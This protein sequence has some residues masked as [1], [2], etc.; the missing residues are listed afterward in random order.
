MKIKWWMVLL[1]IL[2]PEFLLAQSIKNNGIKLGYTSSGIYGTF[3]ENTYNLTSR[4]N[5]YHAALFIEYCNY[6]FFSLVSQIEYA[7]K[8]FIEKQAETDETGQ[9]IQDVKANTRLDYVSIPLFV[10]IKYSKI[11]LN[12]YVIFGPRFDYLVNRRNGIFK[13]SKIDFNS[14]FADYLNINK[15]VF[16]S[17]IGMGFNLPKISLFESFLELRYNH[18]FT[19]SFFINEENTVRNNSFDLWLGISF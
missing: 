2:L 11:K 6:S 16:G 1:L 13:F 12:P 4:R 18:D 3:S 14:Q 19:D 9:F 5:C 15:S 8:G 17:S 10:K 7:Q